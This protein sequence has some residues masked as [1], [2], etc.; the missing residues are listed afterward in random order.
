MFP[1]D[2][3]S[4]IGDFLK[5]LNIDEVVIK[6]IL[7]NLADAED[8]MP[9]DEPFRPVSVTGFSGFA[10]GARMSVHT[11]AAQEYLAAAMLEMA[12]TLGLYRDGVIAFKKGNVTLDEFSA[13]ELTRIRHATEVASELTL[14]DGPGKGAHA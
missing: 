10:G 14:H 12:Q 2:F 5:E 7:D 9:R 3:I 13:D 8:Q 11:N 1:S 6:E 4:G